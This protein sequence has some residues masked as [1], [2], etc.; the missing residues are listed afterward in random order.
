MKNTRNNNYHLISQ[1]IDAPPD[2]CPISGKPLDNKAIEFSV[3]NKKVRV[4]SHECMIK[5]KN[6]YNYLV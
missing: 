3:N 5:V 2:A 6:I 1:I 4:C